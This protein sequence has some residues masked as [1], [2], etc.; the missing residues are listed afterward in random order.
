[1]PLT[2]KRITTWEYIKDLF[3]ADD[4]VAIHM[5]RAKD[6]DS[7]WTQRIVRATIVCTPRFQGWLRAMNVQ[8]Q[9]IYIAVNPLRPGARSRQKTEILEVRRVYIDIDDDGDA[10]IA[11]I[12]SHPT[13]PKPYYVL[14]S[15]PH[16]YQ[17]IWNVTGF[18][19]PTAEELVRHF[20]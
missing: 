5:K 18:T 15:S 4:I 3:D 6:K 2:A 17:A 7:P 13:L 8:G 1:M 20:N 9:D 12:L 14:N 10:A 11:R 16:K 19:E